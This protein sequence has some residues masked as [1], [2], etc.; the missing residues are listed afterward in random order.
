ML[1]IEQSSVPL[2]V[3][4]VVV[5]LA[6]YFFLLGILN[7]RGHPQVLSGRRDFAMLTAALSPVFV[8][9]AANWL[10]VSLWVVAFAAVTLSLSIWAL[11]PRGSS[12]VIYNIPRRR[13]GEVIA[14]ALDQAGFN[15]EASDGGY[16]TI[17]GV[18]VILSCFP[19][20]QNVTVRIVD[21]DREVAARFYRALEAELSGIRVQSS[22]MGVA[23]LLVAT[24]MLVAPLTL[25][26]HRAGEIVRI[27]TD[28]LQ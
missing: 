24:V 14:R 18:K 9:P 15:Y 25:V 12:W 19:L 21:G 27:L 17:E 11:A 4:T 16:R 13:V 6:G 7:S 22:P 2:G 20:L 28:L 26:A 23:M 3:A 10:G 8:L 5:P 1:G